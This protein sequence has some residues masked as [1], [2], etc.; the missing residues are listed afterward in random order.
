MLLSKFVVPT[1][2]MMGVM[3]GISTYW[4]MVRVDL[5][6]NCLLNIWPSLFDLQLIPKLA[7]R[8]ELESLLSVSLS[9]F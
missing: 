5:H 4:G 1:I 9:K 3:G 6:L 2:A 7:K 8:V